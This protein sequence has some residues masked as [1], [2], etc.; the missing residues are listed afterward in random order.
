HP[1]PRPHAMAQSVFPMAHSKRGDDSA[2][3]ATSGYS[4]GRARREPDIESQNHFSEEVGSRACS[5]DITERWR[6]LCVGASRSRAPERR[7]TGG[8]D[9]RFRSSFNCRSANGFRSQY[10]RWTW[11]PSVRWMPL[12][13]TDQPASTGNVGESPMSFYFKRDLVF[14]A[15]SHCRHGHP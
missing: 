5:R 11:D 3:T 2:S 13:A 10:Q 6:G 14:G 8:T 1:L 7:V 4:I 15:W 12:D 9:A